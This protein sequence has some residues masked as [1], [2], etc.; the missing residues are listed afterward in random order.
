MDFAGIIEYIR[1]QNPSAADRIARTIDDSVTS[2]ESFP[3]RG[4]PGRIE[5]TRESVLIPLPFIVCISDQ[6]E[7][8]RGYS[9][10]RLTT[11]ALNVAASPGG[12]QGFSSTANPRT[13]SLNI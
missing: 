7:R 11:L 4:R 13:I 6:G 5:D 9:A 12:N 8:R 10:A 3:Q 1:V 2:L